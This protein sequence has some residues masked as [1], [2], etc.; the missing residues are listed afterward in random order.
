MT[1]V[2]DISLQFLKWR[3]KTHPGAKRAYDWIQ[4]DI[5]SM[6]W[7]RWLTAKDSV[8]M[9]SRERLT[10]EHNQR[11]LAELR[12]KLHVLKA[13]QGQQIA[14]TPMTWSELEHDL[15]V[16][17]R[18]NERLTSSLFVYANMRHSLFFLARLS[19]RRVSNPR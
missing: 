14:P 8:L 10:K 12:A 3:F 6:G 19:K 17:I 16:L 1:I 13:I 9:A 18:F 7:H 15:E 4:E 5:E 11:R 2:S